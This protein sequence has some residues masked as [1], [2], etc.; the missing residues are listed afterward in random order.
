MLFMQANIFCYLDENHQYVYG[1]YFRPASLIYIN[2]IVAAA[3]LIYLKRVRIAGIE[4]VMRYTGRLK[5][6]AE[7]ITGRVKLCSNINLL[8]GRD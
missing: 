3:E 2:S 8:K 1:N 6:G 5:C 7:T 4:A